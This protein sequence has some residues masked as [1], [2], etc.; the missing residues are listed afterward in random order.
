MPLRIPQTR[1]SARSENAKTDS[2]VSLYHLEW[3]EVGRI[4]SIRSIVVVAVAAPII[5]GRICRAASEYDRQNEQKK[6]R[7]RPELHVR[8]SPL[9]I[10]PDIWSRVICAS[11]VGIR[12]SHLVNH[13]TP[14]QPWWSVIA[15]SYVRCPA[16]AG[17]MQFTGWP[18]AAWPAPP[19]RLAPLPAP[20][21]P[22][23]HPGHRPV[24]CPAFRRRPC[25]PP[26]PMRHAPVPPR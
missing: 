14:S 22:A 2:N 18:T 11:T 23:R 15:S 25:H 6:R 19:K 5:V 7:W 10:E 16:V 8:F 1:T 9:C 26:R 20:H 21:P 13:P 3:T 12:Q 24:P 4:V 17:F